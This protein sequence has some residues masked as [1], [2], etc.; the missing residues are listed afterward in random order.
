MM[1]VVCGYRF[2]VAMEHGL[3]TYQAVMIAFYASR[4]GSTIR[5]ACD[6]HLRVLGRYFFNHDL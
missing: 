6:A 3:H 2:K 5:V 4:H 1:W